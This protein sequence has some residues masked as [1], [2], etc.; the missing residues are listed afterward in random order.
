MVEFVDFHNLGRWT[1]NLNLL[2]SDSPLTQPES[3]GTLCYA[4]ESMG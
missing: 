3:E 1:G 4:R 2:T